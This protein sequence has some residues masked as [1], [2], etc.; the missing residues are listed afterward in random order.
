MPLSSLKS[1]LFLLVSKNEENHSH[2]L[3]PR[4][5]GSKILGTKSNAT[6]WAWVAKSAGILWIN[7]IKE[8]LWSLWWKGI[9]RFWEQKTEFR[10]KTGDYQTLYGLWCTPKVFRFYSINTINS[11]WGYL[12]II[13]SRIFF[14]GVIFGELPKEISHVTFQINYFKKAWNILKKDLTGLFQ[15]FFENGIVNSRTNETY[16]CLILKKVRTSKVSDFRPISLVTS[17]QN[18]CQSSWNNSSFSSKVK[19]HCSLF[20]FYFYCCF[21]PYTSSICWVLAKSNCNLLIYCRMHCLHLKKVKYL[22]NACH[23]LKKWRKY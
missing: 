23:L 6:L 1:K 21:S 4:P 17:L 19:N 20:Y 8:P 15:D 16:I 22:L 12:I 11:C 10:G 2:L 14:D 7:M 13:N 18:Y 9:I 3:F 5:Y